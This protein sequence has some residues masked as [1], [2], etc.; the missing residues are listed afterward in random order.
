[1]TCFIIKCYY[2]LYTALSEH[3]FGYFRGLNGGQLSVILMNTLSIP[4]NFTIEAPV[5]GFY[6]SGVVDGN[7][8]TIVNLPFSVAVFRNDRDYK[9]VYLRT[10]SNT[11]TVIGQN[12]VSQYSETFLILPYKRSNVL[13]E[14]VYYGMSVP[15]YHSSYQGAILIVGTEDNTTMKL[16]VTQTATTNFGNTLYTGREYSFV[17]NRLQ[18][19]YIRSSSYT[20]DLTGTKIVTNKQVSVFSGHELTQI[21]QST[22]CNNALIEQVPPVTS[23]GRVFYTMPLATRRYYIIKMLA[24]HHSTKIDLY[25]NNFKYS[26]ALN[27]KQYSTR[28]LSQSEYCVIQSNKPILVAQLSRGGYDERDYIGDPILMMIPDVLQFSNRFSITTIRNPS[29]SGYRH[30]VNIIVLAQYYQPDMIHLISGGRNI[31]LNT[32]RWSPIRVEHTIEAYTTQVTLSEGVAE[33]TH[34]NIDGLMA[35]TMYGVTSYE[36]YGHPGRLGYATG[37]SICSALN[38]EIKISFILSINY[39]LTV[40]LEKVLKYFRQKQYVLY[41]AKESWCGQV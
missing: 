37:L 21:P 31:S 15:G 1:M 33:I 8:D 38:F 36:S 32:Q 2:S 6:H 23:W 3:Y 14:Y 34:T 19:F 25:C 17:I 9:G 29:R 28:T 4:L 5:A 16:T 30:Y 7:N 22:C 13:T 18:T 35:V 26:Y 40:I 11:V 20:S 10:D 39:A 27:E 12:V 41:T 24:S